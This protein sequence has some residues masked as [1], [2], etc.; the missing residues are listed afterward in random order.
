MSVESLFV[1]VRAKNNVEGEEA[2]HTDVHIVLTRGRFWA[3]ASDSAWS[4]G[5]PRYENDR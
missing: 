3:V 2:S 1:R 4:D 5:E